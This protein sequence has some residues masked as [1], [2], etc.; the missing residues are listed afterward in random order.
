MNSHSQ[1]LQKWGA[2]FRSNKRLLAGLLLILGVFAFEGAVRWSE[3]LSQQ[4]ATLARLQTELATLRSQ[5][6]D[7]ATL[8]SQLTQVKLLA[9]HVD[10]RLWTVSSEAVGQARLKDWLTEVVKRSIADQYTITL[11]A[12][13]ELGSNANA[14]DASPARTSQAPAKPQVASVREFRATVSYIM[15]PQALEGVLLA[16]EAGEPFAAVESLNVKGVERRVEM[17]V[18]VLMR[19]KADAN[20]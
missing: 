6:R 16:I 5:A 19:I 15:T 9:T 18:R 17:T 8:R 1:M 11:A 14:S 10:A 2:E 3:F 7:E 12:S 20:V 4:Q 13:R